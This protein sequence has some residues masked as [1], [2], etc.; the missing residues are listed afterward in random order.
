MIKSRLEF[1]EEILNSGGIFSFE[2]GKSLERALWNLV[3]P[4]FLL[5]KICETYVVTIGKYSTKYFILGTHSIY[6][7]S[8]GYDSR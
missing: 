1:T 4:E 7:T 5:I 8:N 6:P 2:G 3:Q